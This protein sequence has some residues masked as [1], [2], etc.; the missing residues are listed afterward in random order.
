M[1]LSFRDYIL[2]FRWIQYTL[3]LL[4]VGD[5]ILFICCISLQERYTTNISEF[6][7]YTL[8]QKKK[9]LY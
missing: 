8:D 3:S 4:R 2:T 5:F 6:V 7:I 9:K 1:H